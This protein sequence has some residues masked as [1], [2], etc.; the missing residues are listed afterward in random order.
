MT[1]DL[2]ETR[3]RLREV[4]VDHDEPVAI[5]AMGCRFPGGVRSPEQLWQLVA[6]GT[7]AIGGFPEDRGWDVDALYDPDPDRAGHTYSRH[8]GFLYDADRFD[9]AFFGLSPREALAMD[10]QQRLLLEVTWETLERARIDPA[11]VR[12][13]RTGVFAGVMYNDYASR[14]RPMPA[15]FE[16]YLG[17]GSAGSIASGRISYVFG[18]EGPAVTV[19]TACSSSL[20]AAHLAARALRSRECDLALAGGVTVMATPSTFIEFSRQRG[21]APDGR[22]KA[23]SADADGTGWAEGAGLILLER[24]SDARRHGHPVLALLRGSAVNQDGTSSQLTAPNGPSQQ[25]MIRAAL[26]A[27]GLTAADVD[28]LEAHGTG[29][30]LGD[31]IEAQAVLATYG[32]DRPADQ[33]L[34]LGSLKS[35]IGHTQAAAGVAG[36]I[37]MVEAMRHGVLPATLHAGTPSPHVDWSAGE[38]RLLTEPRAWPRHDRPRR[39]AVSS[40]GISGTNA[41]V[42]LEQVTEPPGQPEAGATDPLAP[43]HPLVVLPLSGRGDGALREQA[44]LLRDVLA[45]AGGPALADVARTLTTRADLEDRAVVVAADR[46]TAVAALDALVRREAAAGL[47]TGGNTEPGSIAVMFAGQGSQRVGMGRD[48][49]ATFPVFAAALDEVC[50]MFDEHLDHPLR[51]VMFTGAGLLDRTAYTQAALFA[52]EVALYRLIESCGPVP[53]FLLGHSIGELVAAHVAGV[54]SLADA[55]TLV[56][57][58]GRLMESAR[59]DGA[60]LAVE[61]TEEA[62]RDWLAGRP[63]VAVAAVNGPRA[64]VVSGDAAG[65]ADAETHFAAAGMRTRRLRV[66][67]AFHSPHMD[68]VLDRFAEVTS[69][70]TFSPPRIPVVSNITGRLADAEQLCD[71]A[72]WVRHIREAVRFGDGLRELAAQGVTTLVEVGPHSVLT[73]MAEQAL[74]GRSGV[75]VTAAQRDGRPQPEAFLT[76]LATVHVQGTPVRWPGLPPSAGF[77]DLPT[78][79]FQR[80][81]Y[82]LDAPEGMLDAG[83]L[84]L[85]P[86]GH[87]LLGAR[88]EQADVDALLLTGRV[89]VRTQPWLA[90][91]RIGDSV[92]LPGTALVELALTAGGHAGCDLLHELTVEAPLVLPESGGR[93]LRLHV[94]EPAADGE[95]VVTVHSR[96][97]DDGEPAGPDGW[98]RHAVGVL[99]PAGTRETPVEGGQWPP[100]GA[101]RVS[102]AGIYDSLADLGYG[103]GPAFQSVEAAWRDGDHTYAEIRLQPGLEP[104]GFA[105]HPALF[106]AALHLLAAEDGAERPRVPF[107]WRDVQISGTP[108]ETLRACLTRCGTDEFALVLTGDDG[109]PV[110]SVGSLVVRPV[111]AEQLAGSSRTRF[112]LDW[113]PQAAPPAAPDDGRWAV[114]G[115]PG[116]SVPEGASHYPDLAALRDALDAGRPVPAAVVAAVPD[117]PDDVVAAGH[118]AV[119]HALDLVQQWLDEPRLADARLVVVTRDAVAAVPGDQVS[120]VAQSPAWGLIRVAQTE[121]PGRFQLV[122]VDGTPWSALPELLSVT[123]P[124]VAVRDG[125]TLV[126]RLTRITAAPAESPQLDG[127]V[128]ITGAGGALG[129]LVARRLVA[130]HG[131]RHLLLAARGGVDPALVEELAGLGCAVSDQR[132]DVADRDALAAMLDTVPEDR[133]LSAVVH[134]AAVL[135]DGVLTSL[136][137]EQV[138]AVLR[139]KVDAAWHLHELTRD[140]PEIRL[141]LFSSAAG[142][143]GNGGQGGYAAGNTFLDALAQHRRALG[144]PAVSLAW[145]LWDVESTLTRGLGGEG[146]TRAGLTALAPGEGLAALDAALATEEALLIPMALDAPA[147]RSRAQAGNLPAV[148]RGLVRSPARTRAGVSSLA[149]RLA[150]APAEERDGLLE[151]VVRTSVAAVLGHPASAP[152]DPR[153][154]FRDMGFDSLTA[155]ELRNR[156]DAATGL[157]LTA[158]LVFDHPTPAAVVRHL[159]EA[160]EGAATGRAVTAQTTGDEPIAVVGMSCRLPGGVRSPE[161]F[162]ELL[163]SGGDAVGSFPVNR[164]WD[165]AGLFDAD[166]DG[167]GTSYVDQGGFL[168]DADEFD[169]EFFGISPREAMAMDPQQRV[170]L[171]LSWEAVERAGFDPAALRGSSTG[172]FVGLMYHDYG[173]GVTDPP[174]GSEGYFLT[175][176]T[177]SVASGRISYTL[178]L[179]GPAVTVD[180]ACSSSLVAV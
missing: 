22:C 20:V 150:Q 103:Y 89:S 63:D 68:G 23:F 79:A 180:T 87:P 90:D 47:V 96:A 165:L 73:P 167:V 153:R 178:G 86:T 67:H 147:L 109:R 1:A 48:L 176:G 77:A 30:R 151:D 12:G 82:W 80:E 122:D 14:M 106:D 66:S 27:A 53:R 16:G 17:S 6:T 155:V 111:T 159:R 143:L 50:A 62:V 58:R 127:T 99:A 81:R 60:M 85:A 32:Q 110:A 57:A 131:V 160:F 74:G 105:L 133:P 93:L 31:P 152:L 36:I 170:L 132:C 33:P 24:L 21:L 116:D 157:H 56:A 15:A 34:W 95:R 108:G 148:L 136:T 2:A 65:V 9:A 112:R 71:P 104:D 84:G 29:T 141:L 145:G 44:G 156:L 164:G 115:G 38:V 55:C 59:D 154:L 120:G 19:D 101:V 54:L 4:E 138:D 3:Q 125:R 51:D 88:V 172:V 8:G 10:P 161:D 28:A 163:V 35:N 114:L 42:I 144:L 166:P 94:A 78:Y 25:R 49:A 149:T 61:E 7:D 173:V 174:E 72:Y 69:G 11:S 70:L 158:T 169:A 13:S 129:G 18:F 45:A 26:S 137:V 107:A 130:R 113:I 140:R 83:R 124:Q 37:K 162:W 46:A 126:P 171:E 92:V 168:Y 123:E 5:V 134:A 75:V 118:L 39:A 177:G 179:E 146:A 139:A 76:A 100:P 43:E 142:L 128:L 41:H 119:G 121:H 64:V 98:T 40:F 102:T 175:G 135:D 52:Y 91:H 97:D 117:G